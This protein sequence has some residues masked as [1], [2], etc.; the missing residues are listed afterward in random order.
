MDVVDHEI[1]R[2]L[3]EELLPKWS[4][5]F[6]KEALYATIAKQTSRNHE[7]TSVGH[8]HI[9]S[10]DWQSMLKG[11]AMPSQLARLKHNLGSNAQGKG[12]E[13]A[14]LTHIGISDTEDTID[15]PVRRDLVNA[16]D[17]DTWLIEGQPYYKLEYDNPN[18]EIVAR[19]RLIA[20]QYGN[21]YEDREQLWVMRRDEMLI[22]FVAIREA[23]GDKLSAPDPEL[24]K[25]ELE[26]RKLMNG[27]KK[28]TQ[29]PENRNYEHRSGRLNDILEPLLDRPLDNR[30][31]Y[32]RELL[33]TVYHKDS[34]NTSGLDQLA[35]F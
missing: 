7:L 19:K 15:A 31:P 18:G 28:A 4:E 34:D 16:R 5:S 32:I 6:V 12:L 14:R 27:I 26:A 11:T 24:T 30:P 9:A 20:T 13:I 3:D 17:T 8:L 25:E 29:N 10:G 35:L 21:P 1:K 23:L 2:A 22:D 33:T